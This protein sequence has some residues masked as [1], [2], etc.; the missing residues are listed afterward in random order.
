VLGVLSR[1]GKTAGASADKKP[2]GG[3]GALLGRA[4]SLPDAG[5]VRRGRRARAGLR[6]AQKNPLRVIPPQMTVVGWMELAA[7]RDLPWVDRLLSQVPAAKRK[8][9]ESK[10]ATMGIV[11]RQV[12]GVAMGMSFPEKEGADPL[13]LFA[14]SGKIRGRA[15]AKAFAK[16][17]KAKKKRLY[18]Y[19]VLAKDDGRLVIPS[20][21]FVLMAS[22]KILKHGLSRMSRRRVKGF[23]AQGWGQEVAKAGKLRKRPHLLLGIALPDTAR[24]ASGELLAK[25]KAGTAEDSVQQVLIYANASRTGLSLTVAGACSSARV[26]GK[27][28]ALIPTLLEV[29]ASKLP[30]PL[31]SLLQG[32]TVASRGRAFLLRTDLTAKQLQL[33][34]TMLTQAL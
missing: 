22:D 16:D 1:R 11:P 31:Q 7:F 3:L 23:L 25:L 20:R 19:R 27:I 34:G 24:K 13:M 6:A 12:D 28:K 9:V 10:L 30:A 33:L 21:R 26:A 15:L 8:E 4:R 29:G 5:R 32:I 2:V 14:V 18:G 17:G